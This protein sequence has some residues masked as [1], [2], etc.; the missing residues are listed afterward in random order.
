MRLTRPLGLAAVAFVSMLIPEA[1]AEWARDPDHNVL[2]STDKTGSAWTPPALTHDPAGNT[3]IALQTIYAHV[4]K[5]DANGNLLWGPKG[6]PATQTATSKVGQLA[7]SDGQDGV[8]VAWLNNYYSGGNAYVYA[9]KLN[10][11]GQPQ[12]GPDGVA[13]CTAPGI[14]YDLVACSVGEGGIYLAWSDR[15][16][17]TNSNEDADDIYAQRVNATGQVLWM[18]N[19]APVCLTPG[20]QNQT[21]IL[22]S[23]SGGPLIAWHAILPVSQDDGKI[24]VQYLKLDGTPLWAVDG[25]RVAITT[26]DQG[27][28]RLG[29]RRGRSAGRR[30]RLAVDPPNR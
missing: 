17:G 1:R 2:L 28:P 7:V 26:A 3:F 8:I 19:G 12:W 13:V 6:I 24:W 25:V 27:S 29:S 18:V 23:A 21:Q 11:A 20:K 14:R 22:L 4:Q 10:A 9:Q 16:G 5:L 30:P 15:R